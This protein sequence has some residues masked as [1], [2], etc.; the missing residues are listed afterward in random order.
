[1]LLNI[2]YTINGETI[3][4][5]V[6][7][8]DDIF[9][10]KGAINDDIF[11]E[12]EGHTSSEA[13]NNFCELYDQEL[14]KALNKTKIEEKNNKEEQEEKNG[15]EERKNKDTLM[16][17]V[18]Q[19]NNFSE[20][21]YLLDTGYNMLKKDYN[22][23]NKSYHELLTKN[24]KQSKLIKDYQNAL[25]KAEDELKE[26]TSD[27]L[28]TIDNL[29]ENYMNLYNQHQELKENQNNKSNSKDFLK[30]M[31]TPKDFFWFLDF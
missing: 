30:E 17:D 26:I 6:E 14:E 10:A 1:M 18:D 20:N 24:E 23:L 4:F 7:K 2:N 19:L 25:D 16:V 29:C 13:I 22:E 9:V 11:L 12:A 3:H 28:D 15:K 27:L 5:S 31:L 8:E 21:Y